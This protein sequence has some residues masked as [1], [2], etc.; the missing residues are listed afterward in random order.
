MALSAEDLTTTPIGGVPA[1]HVLTV[2]G[3]IEPIL[4]RVVTPET[5]F[6]LAHVLAQLHDGMWQLWVVGNFDAVIITSIE[7]RPLHKVLWVHYCAGDDLEDWLDDWLHLQDE[8]ARA[9]NCASIEFM[10]RVGWSR[11]LA[12]RGYSRKMVLMV[13][14]L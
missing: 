1:E 2:W 14:E 13:K 10:G 6:D 7:I 12:S 3:K 4:K 5:G 11:V 8:F 9:H